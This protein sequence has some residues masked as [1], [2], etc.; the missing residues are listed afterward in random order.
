MY[1]RPMPDIA[2][3]LLPEAEL[4]RQWQALQASQ[5]EEEEEAWQDAKELWFSNAAS[6]LTAEGRSHWWCKHAKLITPMLEIFFHV[7]ASKEV[8]ALWN[9]A[10]R[11][12]G[13]C[14]QCV[15]QHH[16]AIAALREEYD[17]G[18]VEPLLQVLQR[19][20]EARMSQQ[21]TVALQTLDA[22]GAGAQQVD[23]TGITLFEVLSY[24][25][26]LEDLE[27]NHKA[28]NL[29][30]QLASTHDIEFA[31]GERYPGLYTFLMHPNERV[32]SIVH[33]M[34]QRLG[35]FGSAEEIAVIE[36]QLKKCMHWLEFDLFDDNGLA[37]VQTND[38]A[39]PRFRQSKLELWSGLHRILCLLDPGVLETEVLARYPAFVSIVLNHIGE[40]S[41]TFWHALRCLNT[42]LSVLGYRMWMH[43]SFT[44]GVVCD[45]LLGQCF[46]A[47]DERI[48]KAVLDVF[49]PFL[50]SLEAMQEEGWAA[51]R[52]RV[53]YFLL[54]QV[55]MSRHFSKLIRGIACKLAF[56]IIKRG[57]TLAPP[58][59]PVECA[60]FWGPALIDKLGDATIMQAVRD[61][62]VACAC[63]VLATD[64][65]VLSKLHCYADTADSESDDDIPL[66]MLA[67]RGT[68]LSAC[69]KASIKAVKQLANE[70]LGHSQELREAAKLAASH[71]DTWSCV[72][73][74]W[75]G[76]ISQTQPAKMPAALSAVVFTAAATMSTAE[77][78][79]MGPTRS[80]ADHA[81][82]PVESMLWTAPRG[83]SDGSKGQQC[84]NTVLARAHG[85]ALLL[86]LKQ[87]FGDYLVKLGAFRVTHGD[88]DTSYMVEC[89][90]LI[91][92]DSDKRI[93]DAGKGVLCHLLNQ[94]DFE[95]AFHV[96]VQ[97]Q[98]SRT[99]LQFMQRALL[100]VQAR[101]LQQCSHATGQLLQLVRR[102]LGASAPP[103]EEHLDLSDE[104]LE[105]LWTENADLQPQ[106]IRAAWQV[107]IHIVEQ[108]K[109]VCK[110]KYVKELCARVFEVLPALWQCQCSLN[111]APDSELQLGWLASLLHWGSGEM[112]EVMLGSIE[113][114]LSAVAMILEDLKGRNAPLPRASVAA[115]ST[116]LQ[117][118]S[119]QDHIRLQ[120]AQYFP[121]SAPGNLASHPVLSMPSK[122]PT[123]SRATPAIRAAQN[124]AQIGP[125]KVTTPDSKQSQPFSNQRAFITE[126]AKDT[127]AV[128]LTDDQPVP[129]RPSHVTTAPGDSSVRGQRMR[130]L[131]DMGFAQG[132]C[133]QALDLHSNDLDQAMIWLLRRNTQQPKH[134]NDGIRPFLTRAQPM[135]ITAEMGASRQQAAAAAASPRARPSV[136]HPAVTGRARTVGAMRAALRSPSGQTAQRT[137]MHNRDTSLPLPSQVGRSE[138]EHQRQQKQRQQIPPHPPRSQ[139][140][141]PAPSPHT[142]TENEPVG[143]EPV[144]QETNDTTEPELK[145]PR[146]PLRP[147]QVP[148]APRR[149][150][151][152]IAVG[153]NNRPGNPVKKSHGEAPAVAAAFK[154]VRMDDWFREILS[155]HYYQIVENE[156]PAD[157][158]RLKTVPVQFQSVGDYQ[159]VFQPLLLEELKAQLQ[160]SHEE[161]PLL[162]E[163]SATVRQ[164]ALDKVD[165]F[166]V[167]RMKVEEGSVAEGVRGVSEN[168]LVLL[169]KPA[170]KGS[171][172]G[173][174]YKMHMLGMVMKR[175]RDSGERGLVLQL[176][177]CLAGSQRAMELKAALLDKSTWKIHR[178]LSLTPQLRE[179]Q[180][181]SGVAA[182][183]IVDALLH[184]KHG[185]IRLTREAQKDHLSSI[186]V[187]Q[188]ILHTKKPSLDCLT[189]LPPALRTLME[190]QFTFDQQTAVNAALDAC[191]NASA[192]Q[193][194]KPGIALVQGPPGT[195]KTKTI[196][197]IVSALL[198]SPAQAETEV[199]GQGARRSGLGAVRDWD[200]DDSTHAYGGA[201]QTAATPTAVTD[202][203]KRHILLCAQS[204]A[205][206]DELIGRILAGGLVGTDG[207]SYV[208]SVVRIG[209]K[210]SVHPTVQSLQARIM[211][212]RTELA[213][214][215]KQVEAR[216]TEKAQADGNA[217]KAE[218]ADAEKEKLERQLDDELYGKR[219]RIFAELSACQAKE[220]QEKEAIAQEGTKLRQDIIKEATIIACTLSGSGSEELTSL[221]TIPKAGIGF[222]A[223]RRAAPSWRGFDAVIIDEAAQALEPATLVPLRSLA[224][225]RSCCVLVGDPKQLP[226]T[227]LSRSAAR[228]GYE[229]S[230]FERLQ[231]A[232]FPV[233]LLS[234]QFRMH[235]AIRQFPSAHFYGGQLVDGATVSAATR[236]LACHERACFGPYVF[237][238][239][240]EGVHGTSSGSR[241]L[242]NP[243]EAEL[244]VE[245]I[246]ALHTMHPQDCTQGRVAV[247]TPYKQQLHEIRSRLAR[248]LGRDLAS[249]VELGTVDGFQ[250]REVDILILSTVR[251]ATE[252]S[253][254]GSKGGIGFVADIRRMNV[255][256][257]RAKRSLWVLGSSAALNVSP[258][259]SALI[260]DATKRGC[261]MSAVRPFSRIVSASGMAKPMVLMDPAPHLPF[262]AVSSETDVAAKRSRPEQVGVGS[263]LTPAVKKPRTTSARPR[264]SVVD[265]NNVVSTSSGS[266]SK[267][268]LMGQEPRTC[269]S[270][271]IQ[272][273]APMS[274]PPAAQQCAERSSRE[275]DN[276]HGSGGST[277]ATRQDQQVDSTQTAFRNGELQRLKDRATAAVSHRKDTSSRPTLSSRAVQSSVARDQ[278]AQA[279]VRDNDAGGSGLQNVSRKPPVHT[280]SQASAKE[281]LGL[282]TNDQS[283]RSSGA[284]RD[285]LQQ[286]KETGA[287]SGLRRERIER[288]EVAEK[289]RV[290]EH[291]ARHKPEMPTELRPKDRARVDQSR[292][293]QEDS[294]QGR[295]T[296]GKVSHSQQQGVQH[297]K[298]MQQAATS[299]KAQAAQSAAVEALPVPP[300]PVDEAAERKR[301]RE[302]AAAS[303]PSMFRSTSKPRQ[304]VAPRSED[305][306]PP[307]PGSQ[308]AG[309]NSRR[310]MDGKDALQPVRPRGQGH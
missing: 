203:A 285:K 261:F 263:S 57:Y 217:D 129:Q 211:V 296:N 125:T 104:E 255:A 26:L 148:N 168:D 221:F 258:H 271:E 207:R 300:P 290:S 85:H 89:C 49:S 54:Q 230:L 103:G 191:N 257:T 248:V 147:V 158:N 185:Q 181:L 178:V 28:A 31:E 50:E 295:A 136:H 109:D 189:G 165:V 13:A 91:S 115:A 20:N 153:P 238:D 2:T 283:L 108:R 159:E 166:H 150:I 222:H 146:V 234:T 46:H 18:S 65:A 121:A 58:A 201:R 140:V 262:P 287:E 86:M 215:G 204:N 71:T 232:G 284:F 45:T 15:V 183:P 21:L 251:A 164:L 110:L 233:V 225:T 218:P 298:V 127:N 23:T 33:P 299:S 171:S 12:L 76:V 309:S 5:S 155:W 187:L 72:P 304:G 122:A 4:L 229:Q 224:G 92:I 138:P 273:H 243:A 246:S 95:R 82:L 220:R 112:H 22:T 292:V 83:S 278:G 223:A 38:Q 96:L 264:S 236:Q 70:P 269:A 199:A 259:W 143:Q 100:S 1:E 216:R 253:Q 228:L 119:T 244:A 193:A 308:Q 61:A 219:R 210:D 87:F 60:H 56:G 30:L 279:R 281:T 272:E 268:G 44:P 266:L 66:N 98:Y 77:P 162:H 114:W 63:V 239:V 202:A 149:Q 277:A 288:T 124:S 116:L 10:A 206:I 32:R 52:R 139:S 7:D 120:L 208:P 242:R 62:A 270:E 101:P 154:T 227:V 144:G 102:L 80:A 40:T 37:V 188:D 78:T 67:S 241:S 276:T 64:A 306:R 289:V 14:A 294:K 307:M 195:G 81:T 9:R 156:D 175:V 123:A 6:Y 192:E 214:V 41:Q 79:R 137:S 179:F 135:H 152:Q 117:S 301:R 237:F 172:G 173:T 157:I 142:R 133:A 118:T 17:D 128:D 36:P 177:L 213:E 245:L 167:A 184:P 186:P 27:I 55:P 265:Y 35:R 254:A 163:D 34:T 256:L 297:A 180:A 94:P 286:A 291:K 169:G 212:L 107:V 161:S 282:R 113:L 68:D 176:R 11:Q 249:K 194:D 305:S 29:V 196:T 19:L 205:A 97:P 48:H 190:E 209:N 73:K 280:S 99:L 260:A 53:L 16:A 126:V 275:P 200:D 174:Q 274:V 111:E 145:R 131:Q 130:I 267:T 170:H 198:A 43:A 42:L 141:S 24:P 75:E 182:I 235:P 303:L 293:R 3:Y 105:R 160:R 197:A 88:A 69:F 47:K 134:Q 51:Q 84:P 231:K 106:V 90:A 132:L 59:P 25:T 226:A 240:V 74:L 247:V 8:K 252:G 93:S 151:I 250:G 302:E 39:R 310:N